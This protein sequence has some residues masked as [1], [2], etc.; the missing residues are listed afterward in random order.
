MSERIKSSHEQ[1]E[2]QPVVAAAHEANPTSHEQAETDPAKALHEARNSVHETAQADNQN[3][4]RQALQAAEK[5]SQPATPRHVNR[6]L[7]QVTLRRELQQIRR[8]LPAPARALSRVIHQPVVRAVSQAAG[9]TVSRPSGLLG[10][11]L[12]AFIGTSSYLYLARHIGFRYNYLVFL[13]LLAGGFI[14]GLAL[15]LAV[16]L[17]TRSRRGQD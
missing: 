13:V 5:A 11:G 6:E 2:T 15:E 4:A 16:Y 10:G 14:L 3:Q 7:K 12:V 9:Q 17:S 8:K 1:H